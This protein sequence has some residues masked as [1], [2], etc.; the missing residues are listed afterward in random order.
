MRLEAAAVFALAALG[1]AAPQGS[2]CARLEG[3]IGGE[4]HCRHS[5][6]QTRSADDVAP[7]TR[8]ILLDGLDGG[9]VMVA[10]PAQTRFADAV[11]PRIQK[12]NKGASKRR[13][14][15]LIDDEW[16]SISSDERRKWSEDSSREPSDNHESQR[17]GVGQ[18]SESTTTTTRSSSSRNTGPAT[19]TTTVESSTTTSSTET[20]TTTSSSESTTS[21]TSQTTT[22]PSSRRTTKTPTSTRTARS[23]WTNKT[24]TSSTYSP[25]RTFA[26]TSNHTM[27][28]TSSRANTTRNSSFATRPAAATATTGTSRSTIIR[29][30][31]PTSTRTR[32]LTPLFSTRTATSYTDPWPRPTQVFDPYDDEDEEEDDYYYH[33]DADKNWKLDDPPFA[34]PRTNK[35]GI[36]IFGPGPSRVVDQGG[37]DDWRPRGTKPLPSIP[38]HVPMRHGSQ[39]PFDGA[40][41]RGD[42]ESRW[43]AAPPSVNIP[44]RVGMVGPWPR[45]ASGT[46]NVDGNSQP[47]RN[48]I[49]PQPPPIWQ[50]QQKVPMPGPQRPSPQWKV[51]HPFFNEQILGPESEIRPIEKPDSLGHDMLDFKTPGRGP[52]EAPNSTP[53]TK[54]PWLLPED[55]PPGRVISL[56]DEYNPASSHQV[57]PSLDLPTEKL[58][59][60]D[61]PIQGPPHRKPG[62]R[63]QAPAPWHGRPAQGVVLDGRRP[64]LNHNTELEA[65]PGS[66]KQKPGESNSP[67][68]PLPATLRSSSKTSQQAPD[69]LLGPGPG[70]APIPRP[71]DPDLLR[72]ALPIAGQQSGRRGPEIAPDKIPGDQDG[73]AGSRPKPNPNSRTQNPWTLTG[74]TGGEKRPQNINPPAK[75]R[76]ATNHGVATNHRPGGKPSAKDQEEWDVFVHPATGKKIYTGGGDASLKGRRAARPRDGPAADTLTRSGRYADREDEASGKNPGTWRRSERESRNRRRSRSRGE[77]LE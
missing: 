11:R 65:Q 76:P 48:G 22:D 31:D 13:I 52:T 67:A 10:S 47:S 23:S 50:P 9:L 35:Q 44:A 69:F 3:R 17:P 18:T 36:G 12:A 77:L 19:T 1:W 64:D 58:T 72:S 61:L 6:H 37:D 20:T 59:Q 73:R 71:G 56:K 60:E 29:T 21:T 30:L 24:R 75:L 55:T 15:E 41:L 38:T 54:V 66:R 2:S 34:P 28:T 26:P 63:M 53:G 32:T 49:R 25:A 70:A 14:E 42:G 43:R 33:G 8:R 74:R 51:N 27:A 57:R 62:P 4:L 39:R 46:K 7:A 16:I 40:E 45:P 5:I 68:A